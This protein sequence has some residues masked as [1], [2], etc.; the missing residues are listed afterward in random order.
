MGLAT[1]RRRSACAWPSRS[2]ATAFTPAFDP[3]RYL[4]VGPRVGFEGNKPP[5]S[6]W[7]V[8]WQV[9]A[10]VLSGDRTSDSNGGVVN[11]GAAELCEQPVRSVN[12]DGLLGL[13]YWF[14]NRVE[15]DSSAIAPI[16]S[17]ARRLGTSPARGGQR[18]PYQP[19]ADDPVQHPEVIKRGALFVRRG[20]LRAQ[21]GVSALRTVEAV[22]PRRRRHELP[23]H[24]AGINCKELRP[25]QRGPLQR[26]ID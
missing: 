18:R 22:R 15:T 5:E 1:S 10:A 19:R 14:D 2:P 13:S 7:V 25:A 24:A 23:K 16:I 21:A 17:K 12:V 26:R 3:R 6:S 4:G 20:A 9:G 11:S 8:E